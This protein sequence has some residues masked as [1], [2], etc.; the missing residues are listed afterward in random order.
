[1]HEQ[2]KFEIRIA[3]VSYINCK[4]VESNAIFWRKDEINGKKSQTKL[5]SWLRMEINNER[6]SGRV[7]SFDYKNCENTRAYS[8]LIEISLY[9]VV[10]S[11]A[12]VLFNWTAIRESQHIKLLITLPST[13]L[14]SA[15]FVHSYRISI[16]QLTHPPLFWTVSA[17][18]WNREP[19]FITLRIKLNYKVI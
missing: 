6:W 9:K 19:Q 11:Q 15:I 3:E 16:N 1:M 12:S 13:S 5:S 18:N 14:L 4:L 17:E 7:R 10:R 2:W 8:E